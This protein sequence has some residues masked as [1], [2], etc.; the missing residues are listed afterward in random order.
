MKTRKFTQARKIDISHTVLHIL[1]LVQ[2]VDGKYGVNYIVQL[3]RAEVKYGLRHPRHAQLCN[4]GIL[5]E[6]TESWVYNLLMFLLKEEYLC[7]RD[8]KYGRVA[9]A[10]KGEQF[11][12]CPSSIAVQPHRLRPGKYDRILRWKLLALRRSISKE[13]EWPPYRIFTDYSMQQI[14]THK[15]KS[16]AELKAIPGIGDFKARN[17]GPLI[18]QAVQETLSLK[19]RERERVI[20]RPSY[21]EVS[22]LFQA[23]MSIEEIA[24]R[25]QVKPA[26]VRQMLIE[27]HQSGQLDLSS[28]IEKQLSPEVLEQGTAYFRDAHDARLKA[29]YQALGLDYDTL[30]L[31]RLY[32]SDVNT[33]EEELKY[34]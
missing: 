20:T 13:R 9:I 14:I 29:A 23:G 32:V 26:T 30:R 24:T 6:R 27:L 17:F 28:W 22:A 18:L 5:S 33:V 16:I 34:S 3:L 7:I 10:P 25:R 31:C 2:A 11:L 15:P 19:E 8:K 21:Q 12:S 4:F 1:Q